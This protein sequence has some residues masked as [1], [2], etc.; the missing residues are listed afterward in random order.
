MEKKERWYPGPKVSRFQEK[1]FGEIQRLRLEETDAHK[2]GR[3]LR[4]VWQDPSGLELERCTFEYDEKGRCTGE[5]WQKSDG[6]VR[7]LKHAHHEDGA[8]ESFWEDVAE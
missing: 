2:D 5:L 4:T 7:R 3:P 6:F 1:E 8:R